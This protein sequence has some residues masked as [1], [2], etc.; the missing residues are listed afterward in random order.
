MSLHLLPASLWI[1]SIKSERC[2][3]QLFDVAGPGLHYHIIP[4][5]L[6]TKFDIM[7]T[8]TLYRFEVDSL[9]L[10][11]DVRRC[12]FG[13]GGPNMPPCHPKLIAK[14][15]GFK[16]HSPPAVVSSLAIKLY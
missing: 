15:L 16:Q 11:C 13:I 14:Q 9:T 2:R 5:C 8:I 4:A 12:G 7:V 1:Y 10:E 6:A 3:A